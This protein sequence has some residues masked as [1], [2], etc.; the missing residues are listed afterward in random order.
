MRRAVLAAALALVAENAYA[1]ILPAEAILSSVAGRRSELAFDTIIAEG[2]RTIAG[3]EGEQPVWIAIKPGVGYR[4][5]IR[6]GGATRVVLTLD[7]KRWTFVEGE[8]T[9]P[10]DRVRADL[11]VDFL[12][13]LDKDGGGKR[14]L[15]F[16][17]AFGIQEKPV[18]F[19]RLE[20]RIAY[21]IGAKPGDESKPQLWVD[22]IHRVPIRL[23]EIDPK[24]KKKTDTRLLGFGSPQTEEWLPQRIETWV[25]GSLVERISID[26]VRVNEPFDI[27]LL[28]SPAR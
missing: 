15:A 25:D 23:I 18:R 9:P 26:R 17:D 16:L 4:M 2:R 11:F 7:R 20:G 13:N 3:V 24:T 28:R 27:T 5:E 21:I 8:K 19:G 1:Y 22:K 6:G 14:G 12:A 10:A